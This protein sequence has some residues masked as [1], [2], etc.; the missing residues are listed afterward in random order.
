MKISY[1]NTRYILDD[2]V[3]LDKDVFKFNNITVKDT[4]G[5]TGVLSG[6]VRHKAF[7]NWFVDLNIDANN[8]TGF[9][10][11]YSYDEM[12][13]GTAVGTGKVKIFGP[14]SNLNFSVNA[15]SEPGTKI[16]IPLNNPGTVSDNDFISFVNKS[17]STQLLN[18]Q[19][20]ATYSGV[21]MNVDVDVTNSA[22]IQLFLPYEMGNI[23]V[24]GNGKIKMGL[25]NAGEFSMYGDYHIS[26]G[27]FQ[28]AM[29]K[30]G[31]SRT[32]KILDDSYIRWS[33]DPYDATIN[34][35]AVN[36]TKVSLA[37]LP[38]ATLNSSQS[39]QRIPV[40]CIVSIKDNL[41]NPKI[42]FSISLPNADESIKRLVFS[43]IDTTNEV[44]MNQQMI[45][46]LIVGGFSLYN[47]TKSLGSSLGASP[48][49]MVSNQL[50]N[51][52]S[53]I[54]KEF[55]IGVNYRPGDNL[56]SQEV[57]VMLS[58]QLFNNRV[59]IDGNLGVSSNNPMLQQRSSNLVGDVNIEVRLTP[60]GRFKLRAY[61]KANNRDIIDIYAAYKQ[62]IG[63]FYRKEFD[64]FSDLFR[65]QKKKLKVIQ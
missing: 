52:L 20:Q 13:Y 5:K 14:A 24:N 57:E 35:R 60:D 49:E 28:F 3:T 1:L 10:K 45:S 56:T 48:Y 38:N 19:G 54:S 63:L 51:M 18:N 33:G 22:A 26:N 41:F 46:L 25:N 29:Q 39:S 37:T 61:N 58:T 65:K 47:E 44:E 55:D 8:L 62:G 64:H 7:S 6:E 12:Y 16:F 59:K 17:D 15:R 9:S 34:M 30:Y 31:L 36:Q 53:Q 43:A 4:L 27:T 23:K 32:F 21:S 42:K 11:G 50:N 2:K 40:D